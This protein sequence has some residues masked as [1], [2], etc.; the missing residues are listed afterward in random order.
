MKKIKF[1]VLVLFGLIASFCYA[2]NTHENQITDN[3]SPTNKVV[4]SSEVEWEQ[5]NPARGDKS[6]QAGTLWGDRKAK[7]ATGYLGK[8]VDGFSSPPHIHNVTYRAIVIKGSIHNHDPSAEKMWMKPGSFWVQP[9]GEAHITAAKGEENLAY[10][11]IDNGPYLVWPSEQAYENDE[12]PLNIDVVNLV[13]LQNSINWVDPNSKAEVSFLWQKKESKLNG[14]FVKLPAGYNGI[15]DSEGEVFY[16][17]VIKGDV[18]YEMP[19]SGEIKDLDIGSCFSSTGKAF[20]KITNENDSDII[21]YIRT[22][23]DIRIK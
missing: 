12:R 6:P 1:T 23:G 10:I 13:W 16:S 3:K 9:V 11:E 22:N 4:L 2:T 20:H 18:K 8:F 7:V 14:L 5:L 19:L 21:L 17:I 15:I